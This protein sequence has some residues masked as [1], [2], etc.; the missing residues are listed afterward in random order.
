MLNL[1]NYLIEFYRMFLFEVTIQPYIDDHKEIR[2]T[3]TLNFYKFNFS[4]KAKERIK[5]VKTKGNINRI[6]EFDLFKK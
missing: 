4:K 3:D 5:K 6:I 1:E 2:K